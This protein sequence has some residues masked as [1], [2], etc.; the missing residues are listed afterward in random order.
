MKQFSA[1]TA[2][3]T[4]ACASLSVSASAA[5]TSREMVLL[6]NMGYSQGRWQAQPAAVL[7]CGGPS[8]PNST[9]ATRSLYQLKNAEGKVLL[10]RYIQNPRILLV[11]DPREPTDLLKET[12]FT[13][14]V[15]IN[16]AGSVAIALEDVRTFEYFEN[17]ANA[18]RPSVV[19]RFDSGKGLAPF[20]QPVDGQTASCVVLDPSKGLPPLRIPPSDALS[21]EQ[22]AALIQKDRESLIRWGLDNDVTPP[23]LR[24]LV[25]QNEKRLSEVHL[26]RAAADKLLQEYETAYKNRRTR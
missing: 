23:E 5:E 17:G 26:D 20:A 14:R 13:L 19:A 15:P 9:S 2:A 24:T 18:G 22:L 4:F 10:Q 11:E 3:V 12:K 1:I 21:P 16:Q 7:P 6:M 25:W 8:K